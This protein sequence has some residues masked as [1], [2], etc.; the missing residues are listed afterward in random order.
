MSNQKQLLDPLG[1][2]CKLIALNFYDSNTKISIHDHIVALD[3]SDQ[4]QWITRSLNKDS[5]ENISELY[6]V[7]VRLILWYLISDT[8]IENCA[9]YE[10]NNNKNNN[11]TREIIISEKSNNAY[12]IRNSEEIRRMI[13]YLCHAFTKLQILTYKHGN[14]VFTLQ[15]YI[16][17][18]TSALDNN[19]D[20]KLLPIHLQEINDSYDNLLDLNKLKNLWEIRDIQRICELYDNCFNVLNDTHLNCTTQQNIINSYL[21]SINSILEITDIKFKNLIKNNNN[22]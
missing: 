1:T 7:I 8:N 15:Y 4:F 19:F 5:K 11:Y 10:S 17:L 2:L 18:L 22:G 20:Y 12:H 14:V 3:I 13:Q 16:N 21:K 6:Y 9:N